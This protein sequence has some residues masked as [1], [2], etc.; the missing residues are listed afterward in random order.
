METVVQV[1]W[2]RSWYWRE[3]LAICEQSL[4]LVYRFRLKLNQLISPQ[5]RKEHGEQ[6]YSRFF[7]VLSVS[8]VVNFFVST[9]KDTLPSLI[10]SWRMSP[11]AL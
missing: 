9:E 10:A 5:M 3:F 1:H 4:M 2:K 8:S 6:L 7:S 11:L